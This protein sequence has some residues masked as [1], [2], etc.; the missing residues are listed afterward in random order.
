MKLK[1]ETLY[2]VQP[3]LDRLLER[4]AV[5]NRHRVKSEKFTYGGRSFTPRPGSALRPR[6]SSDICL[7]DYSTVQRKIPAGYGP[8]CRLQG[9]GGGHN[10][11]RAPC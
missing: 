9:S 7:H 2:L 8:P 11:Q 6:S 1:S 10:S 3:G 5:L 4:W